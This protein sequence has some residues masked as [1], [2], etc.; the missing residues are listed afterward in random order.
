MKEGV[1]G[2]HVLASFLY[3]DGSLF[4]KLVMYVWVR[5]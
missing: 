2:L 5:V 1:H 4:A 3:A